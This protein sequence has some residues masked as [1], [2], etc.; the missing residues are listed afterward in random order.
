MG[1]HSV[2]AVSLSSVDLDA[3]LYQYIHVCV[4]AED[5]HSVSVLMG[6][7]VWVCS[8]LTSPWLLNLVSPYQ[9]FQASRNAVV[10]MQQIW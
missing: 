8:S 7:L 6:P 9:Y 4:P 3:F 1:A 2:C 10:H 5:T